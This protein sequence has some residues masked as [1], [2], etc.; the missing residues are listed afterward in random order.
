VKFT[1]FEP[2][3]VLAHYPKLKELSRGNFVDPVQWVVYPTNICKLKC[4]HCIMQEL[5]KGNEYLPKSTMNKM[6]QDCI[7]L[8]VKSVRF[9]GGGEPTLNLA[10]IPTI[11]RLREA[12][13]EVALDTSLTTYI[14]GLEVDYL[15]VSVDCASRE[16]YIKVHG[17]DKWHD[18]QMNMH[19]LKGCKE[20]GLAYLLRHDNADELVPFLEWA[21][22]FP[23]TFIHVRPAYWPQHNLEI[24]D[25]MQQIML[26]KPALENQYR[27]LTISV[28]KFQGYWTDRT[29]SRCLA[30]GLKSILTADGSFMVCQDRFIKWG[31]YNEQ[32]FE[33]CWYSDEHRD[34]IAKINLDQC[35]RCVEVHPNEIIEHCVCND[36]LKLGLI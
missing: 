32:T 15:R 11:K 14:E 4:G 29:Y 8:G 31:N 27:G 21:Q 18:L 34:A 28:E 20:I 22:Q 19:N 16:G 36:G 30:S 1:R 2:F 5:R 26:Q 9:T 10:T 17:V 12:G 33:E 7:R 24:Q 25:V 23:Y 6:V 3:K 35:P 13:I